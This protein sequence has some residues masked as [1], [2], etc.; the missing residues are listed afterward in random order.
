MS[1]IY[2][3]AIIG[4]G[5]GG[6]FAAYKLA[7]EH[8]DM[9]VLGI[10]LSRPM[11]KRRPQICGFFGCFPTGDGKLYLNDLPKISSI[12]GAKKTKS[13]NSLF[14]NIISN[15]NTFKVTKDRSP[16]LS[17]EKKFK[18]LGY[19]IT[20][21]DFIQTYPKD[22][23]A[24]SRFMV[25]KIEESGNVT[26]SFDNEVSQIFKQ[27][28]IFNIV[29]ERGEFKCKK[30]IIAVGRSG[31]RWANDLFKNF[32]IIDNNDTA[33]FGIRVE[34]TSDIM[35]DFNKSNCTLT[36]ENDLEIGPLS[37]F[38]TVIPEDHIDTAITAFRSN[39]NRWKTDKVSFSLIGNRQ[40]P[41]AGFEQADR[42][43]KLTFILTNDRVMKE[44]LTTLLNSRSKISI[45]PEYDWLKDAVNELGIVVP[46]LVSKGYFHIPTIITMA[47]KIN[48]SSNLESEI[49]GMF[50]IGE[51]A[52]ISGILAAGCMGL[53]AADAVC[54]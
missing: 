15:V 46:E 29:T 47:P 51:S 36:K 40:F 13:S 17:L 45:I 23:H 27:K 20:L 35:K 7:K 3:V 10:E 8:K 9:K 37:W 52:G 42:L 14:N 21:N 5:V 48:L 24:L 2:D 12:I 28:N 18:K 53:A 25:N 41:A 11:S 43:A 16:N 19:D 44:K 22:V 39:E 32:G 33:K 1:N 50:V 31:W 30:V 34:T 4:M 6:V 38:G 54:K 49:D 26:Y